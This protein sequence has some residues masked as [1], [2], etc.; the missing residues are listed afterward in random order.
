M[1]LLI[2]P[3]MTMNGTIFPSFD[4]SGRQLAVDFNDMV[5][6]P[7]GELPPH[8]SG[9]MGPYCDRLTEVLSTSDIATGGRPW[10]AIGHSF[11]GMLLLAWLLARGQGQGQESP[12]PDGIV[13]IATTAGPMF[14]RVAL[15]LG[16]LGRRE[17][18]VGIGPLLGWWNRPLV[19]RATKW[20]LSGGTLR[21]RPVDF[22]HLSSRSDMAADLAGWRNTDWRAMRS[23]R[24]AMDGFDVRDELDRIPVPTVVLHGDRDTLFPVSAAADLADGLPQGELRIVPGAGHLLPLTCGDTVRQA[25]SD[26]DGAIDDQ[27]VP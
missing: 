22:R 5:V 2:L 16:R 1:D 10:I 24:L 8:P 19:T 13:L 21:T 6:G 25:V 14:D 7:R 17:V 23:Y 11:G 20:L 3:G 18:R 15:R 12:R 27:P 4:V 9:P 26:L